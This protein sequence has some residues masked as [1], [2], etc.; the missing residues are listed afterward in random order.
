MHA[1]LVMAQVDAA[2]AAG[3]SHLMAS[4]HGTTDV[5]QARMWCAH[6]FLTQDKK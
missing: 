3:A 5:R 6:P 4:G 1:V 2:E